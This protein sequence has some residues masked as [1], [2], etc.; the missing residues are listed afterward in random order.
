MYYEIPVYTIFSRCL[1]FVILVFHMTTSVSVKIVSSLIITTF[2]AGRQSIVW[3][4][5]V[6]TTRR[7]LNTNHCQVQQK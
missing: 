4:T 1:G 3:A 7:P 2:S 5:A 6:L